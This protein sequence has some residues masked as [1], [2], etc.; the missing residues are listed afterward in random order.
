MTMNVGRQI[1]DLRRMT[2]TQLRQKHLEAF[3]EPI[4]SGHKDYL[5]KRIAWRLQ[6]QEAGD[7][8]ERARRRA[9]QLANDADLRTTAP[10]H[11]TDDTAPGITTRAATLPP[12]DHD[13]RLPLPGSFVNRARLAQAATLVEA[14]SGREKRRDHLPK[15]IRPT[16]A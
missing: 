12:T 2:V 6:A 4:R 10:K 15:L 3:G 11:P 16:H 13:P 14:A 1:A 9:E 5:V 7:L 8:S